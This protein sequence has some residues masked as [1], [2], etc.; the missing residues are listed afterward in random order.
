[1]LACGGP[2][3]QHDWHPCKKRR[4]RQGQ[5]HR[6][7]T[8]TW[9]RLERC[10]REPRPTEGLQPL[11]GAGKGKGSPLQTSE[12]SRLCRHAGLRL[13]ASRSAKQ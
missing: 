6:Q 13:G 5:T 7:G 1:M 11:P 4:E 2:C 8:A 3:I 12:G 10:A 9:R